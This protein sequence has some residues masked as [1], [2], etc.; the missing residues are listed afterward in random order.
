[1][2]LYYKNLTFQ[3]VVEIA[4]SCESTEAE[5]KSLHIL[6]ETTLNEV[7]TLKL[8]KSKIEKCAPTP[9]EGRYSPRKQ[10]DFKEKAWYRCSKNNLPR[11]CQFNFLQFFL[12]IRTL[13]Q[14]N[15]CCRNQNVKIIMFL[16]TFCLI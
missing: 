11:Y 1:M 9:K 13:R 2:L 14:F 15:V 7:H 10:N 5:V 12:Q 16:K 6:E 8:E 4:E 3:T